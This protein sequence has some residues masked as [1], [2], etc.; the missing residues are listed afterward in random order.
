MGRHI[1]QQHCYSIAHGLLRKKTARILVR[2]FL[3]HPKREIVSHTE[4]G[5]KEKETD[6]PR[7]LATVVLVP[8][9]C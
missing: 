3:G 7:C 4:T 8:A 6:G 2:K 9:R 1:P 5:K